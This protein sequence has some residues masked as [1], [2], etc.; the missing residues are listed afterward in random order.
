MEGYNTDDMYKV[1]L[2]MIRNPSS[3]G[4]EMMAN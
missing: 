2:K 1:K 4:R 3:K